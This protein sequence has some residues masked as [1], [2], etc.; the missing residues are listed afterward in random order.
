[1]AVS[2]LLVALLLLIC[3]S[4]AAALETDQYYTWGRPLADS[5]DVLNAKVNVELRAGLAELNETRHWNDLSCKDAARETTK[6][7]RLFII[8]PF[9]MWT[10]NSPLVARIPVDSEEEL[11]YR[12]EF[13]LHRYAKLDFGSWIPPTPTVKV[14]DVR[15]GT[16][17]LTH[18]FSEGFWYYRW[19]LRAR[20]DGLSKEDA[21]HQAMERGVP[22]EQ[23]I[24]GTDA[25]G[26]FSPADLEANHA[27]LLFMIQMCEGD[28]PRLRKTDDG[29]QM[30]RRFDFREF[31]T[32][33]WD[34]S[35]Q[36]SAFSKRRWKRV[37]PV[38]LSYCPRLELPEVRAERRDY[39]SR[40][41]TTPTERLIDR[42][43]EEG[44]LADPKRFAIEA[45]CAEAAADGAADGSAHGQQGGE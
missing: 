21:L 7:F 5:T 35:W 34:E 26:V 22:W 43:I 24:L 25:S 17:K 18:F 41:R 45:V 38:L 42:L 15:L 36:P 10:I 11:R 39:A 28:E 12:K 23:M 30:T 14:N 31:V 1:M 13:L 19:Y 4:P 9:E 2:R 33:E 3:V 20:K 40:D 8:H 16:D 29:W 32:P 27:G 6:R 44:E 37:R